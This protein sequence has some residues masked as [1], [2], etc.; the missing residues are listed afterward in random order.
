[1]AHGQRLAVAR[2]MKPSLYWLLIFIP[3]TLVLE[4]APC[5]RS[6]AVLF[7]GAGDHPDRQHDC[8]CDGTDR[9]ADR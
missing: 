2:A 5:T 4:H 1:M 6:T 8:A 7:R 9:D 3:I